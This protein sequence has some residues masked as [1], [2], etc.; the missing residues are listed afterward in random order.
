MSAHGVGQFC[1]DL[2][3]DPSDISLVLHD[4]HV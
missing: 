2:D 4:H 3:V 1:E